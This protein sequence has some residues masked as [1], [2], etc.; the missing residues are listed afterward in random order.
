MFGVKI[1]KFLVLVLLL[2]SFVSA[3]DVRVLVSRPGESRSVAEREEAWFSAMSDAYLHFRFMSLSGA[4]AVDGDS[5]SA[6]F[7]SKGKFGI[8]LSRGQLNN[9]AKAFDAT[10]ILKTDYIPNS[11]EKSIQLTVKLYEVNNPVEIM[12]YS[13]R[14]PMLLSA[15]YLDSAVLK[16][17]EGLEI[18]VDED[19]RGRVLAPILIKNFNLM[20]DLGESVLFISEEKRLKNL[21]KEFATLAAIRDA[22]KNFWL[23]HFMAG[24][25]FE[26]HG[27][28]ADAAEAYKLLSGKRQ[29]RLNG[30]YINTIRNYRLA[31]NLKIA[32]KVLKKANKYDL[33]DIGL[34][35]EMA[36]LRDAEGRIAEAVI[37][38]KSVL[39]EVPHN[40]SAL[41][42][43][44]RHNNSMKKY[45]KSLEQSQLLV[46]LKKTLPEAFLE[47]GI[48]YIGLKNSKEAFLSLKQA[49]TFRGDRSESHI[50]LSNLY[51]DNKQYDS[52]AVHLSEALINRPD[53]A[54]LLIRAA[55]T[56]KSG[57]DFKGALKVLENYQ[58][59]FEGNLKVERE[60]GLTYFSVKDTLRAQKSLEKCIPMDPPS[61]E[62]FLTLS[63]IYLS[64]KSWKPMVSVNEKARPLV[65][66]KK[67]VDYSLGFAHYNLKQ[68]TAS[69][70]SFRRVVAVDSKYPEANRYIGEI[71]FRHQDFSRA[72]TF[73]ISEKKFNGNNVH[74]QERILSSNFQLKSYVAARK[75]A[76]ALINIDSISG[77]AYSHL[78]LISLEEKKYLEAKRH[79]EVAATLGAVDTKVYLSL[80]RGFASAKQWGEA[81]IAY[82]K[83]L[84]YEP[85]DDVAHLEIAL[86]YNNHKAFEKAIT[87]YVMANDLDST[88]N[89]HALAKAGHVLLK[90]QK[91]KRSEEMYQRFITAGGK[92]DLVFQNF[93]GL[94]YNGKFY[95]EA[96][97]SLDQI[98]GKRRADPVVIKLYGQS[99]FKVGI[100]DT[101]LTYLTKAVVK[102]PKNVELAEMTAI[103]YDKTGDYA[104]AVKYLEIVTSIGGNEKRR[105]Y[106][107]Y[108]AQLYEK[109][110]KNGKAQVQ[111]RYNIQ[112]FPKMYENHAALVKH[113]LAAKDYKSS[114]KLLAGPAASGAPATL[115]KPLAIAYSKIDANVKA[116]AAY[117]KYVVAVKND[118]D[119]WNSLGQTY[120]KMKEYGKAIRPFTEASKL[121]P[122]DKWVHYRLANS[123]SNIS[124]VN[125]AQT[126][127]LK[128]W[129]HYK[130]DKDILALFTKVVVATQDTVVMIDVYNERAKLETKNFGLNVELGRL[131][132][133]KKREDEAIVAYQRAL[134]IKPSAFKIRQILIAYYTKKANEEKVFALIQAGLRLHPKSAVL[135]QQRAAYFLRSKELV[136]AKE[137]LKKSVAYNPNNGPAYFT[138]GMVH[139]ELKEPSLSKNALAKSV[140][141]EP[142]NSKYRIE[143]VRVLV[144]LNQLKSAMQHG[145]AVLKL[146]PESYQMVSEIAT[147]FQ[148][149]GKLK[150]AEK[151]YITAIAL[152]ENCGVCYRNL[153]VIYYE[154]GEYSLSEDNLD[155]FMKM[156]TTDWKSNLYLAN[157]KRGAGAEDMAAVYYER[158]YNLNSSDDETYYRYV[159]I[160]AEIGD[161]AKAEIVLDSRP[162]GKSSNWV[163][164]AKGRVA[165]AEENYKDAIANYGMA[166]KLDDGSADA[167]LGLGRI[168]MLRKE[169]DKAIETLGRAMGYDPTNPETYFLLGKVYISLK[170]YHSSEAILLE[171]TRI[172]SKNPDIY[173]YLAMSYSNNRKHDKAVK[174]LKKAL[175]STPKNARINYAL[176]ME[177]M[178]DIKPKESIQRFERTI[179][180]DK[181]N[182]FEL[183]IYKIMGDIYY[184]QLLDNEGAKRCYKKYLKLGGRDQGIKTK[185]KSL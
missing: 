155:K 31:G 81:I 168:Q 8:T 80:G 2:A 86:V 43:L 36:K 169:F 77:F 118:K 50:L 28:N 177:L 71:L 27:M 149:A 74:L 103:S 153:G 52:A 87:S 111:Y 17:A 4:T 116:A 104:N 175:L 102:E 173:Y 62:V 160:L 67:H 171:G 140:K 24:L 5:V 45:G 112:R 19:N 152:D 166:I 100:Y 135:Y 37:A 78:A 110:G 151:L 176:A 148:K 55:V 22:N 136:K 119:A 146:E 33:K 18:P 128:V 29:F 159:N 122:K 126:T 107:F 132:D 89:R 84:G 11:R 60:L 38:F 114:I 141:L 183:K 133:A 65:K 16:I 178:E 53:D 121:M 61:K 48:S 150:R 68:D 143:L 142:K 59:N 42:Y 44:A 109:L 95:P 12:E 88:K 161:V 130:Q 75:E 30:I 182:E 145:E 23:A 147:V 72:L 144:E 40:V 96:I 76:N 158:A 120:Y 25:S 9:A 97:K 14:F 15:D 46:K 7:R 66:V 1:S 63:D 94:K 13:T 92:D 90:T 47:Q 179:Q 181:K 39:K 131:L 91:Y 139:R 125:E 85:K 138:L 134:V 129:P 164:I 162:A 170:D 106:G 35:L 98:V 108:L 79:L 172:N 123:Y 180:F 64:Q 57:K 20:K 41:L 21:E 10:H 3:S 93:A 163:F 54:N 82:N 167:Y 70:E 58:S 165:E 115:N 184:E 69:E 156:D 113:Y 117:E 51:V 185:I 154:A 174:V 105:Q 26:K 83:Y 49:I 101:A 157:L 34:T 56:F 32:D 137:D 6:Y 127:L 73:F 99:K 124:K